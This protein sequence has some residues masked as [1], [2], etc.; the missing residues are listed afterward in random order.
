MNRPF[1]ICALLVCL[2]VS[3]ASAHM[4]MEST[5]TVRF[6]HGRLEVILIMSASMA[7]AYLGEQEPVFV[8]SK[9][10]V[11]LRPRLLERAS[12]LVELAG[13]GVPLR[14]KLCNAG[15]GKGNEAEFLLVY[16]RPESG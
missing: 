5:M 13:G 6:E 7:G 12:K 1:A 15:V 4:P 3:A 9:T 14:M 8:D 2:L 16:P 10:I 11:A